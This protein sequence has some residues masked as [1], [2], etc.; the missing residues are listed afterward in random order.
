MNWIFLVVV[1][2]FFLAIVA[3]IDKYILVSKKVEKPFVLAFYVSSL[4]IF[5][6]LIFL[7][8]F[9]PMPA[10]VADLGL[11]F[12]S[13]DN[14][15]RPSAG[16]IAM[17]FVAGFTFFQ[18]LVSLYSA[19]RQADVS[20][21][22]PVVSS[23]T[24]ISTFLL[25]WLINGDILS[26]NFAEGFILLVVG[27]ALISRFRLHR[28]VV[29][30][31]AHAGI[32][33]ALNATMMKAMFAASNFDHAFFW[34]RMGTIIIMASILLIPRYYRKITENSTKAGA[35]GGL[36]VVGKTAIAGASSLLILKAIELGDVTLVQALGGLQF[37]FLAVFSFFLGPLTPKECGE[38]NRMKDV[39]QKAIAV[40]I[41]FAG[42]FYLFI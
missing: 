5:S 24:A 21:V 11:V 14:V 4:T 27:T 6:L 7:I 17:T 3:I 33:F 37:A 42:F 30:L 32:L 2:Q 26:Q 41:L 9:L 40:A 38:N 10:F 23:V 31:S 18:A 25:S 20:D 29:F 19:F 1:A 35:E 34:S 28:D 22:V 15:G 8:E 36:W 16:M 39:I 13:F 12:P